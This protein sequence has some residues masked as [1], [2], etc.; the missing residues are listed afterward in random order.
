MWEVDRDFREG[1]MQKGVRTF[2]FRFQSKVAFIKNRGKP[3]FLVSSVR[4][5]QGVMNGHVITAMCEWF[6]ITVMW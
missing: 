5:F 6:T 1:I 4:V 2:V 3:D